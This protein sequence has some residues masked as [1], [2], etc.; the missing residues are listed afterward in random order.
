MSHPDIAG[1]QFEISLTEKSKSI[2]RMHFGLLFF[3]S[4]HI[5]L[6]PVSNHLSGR[7][8]F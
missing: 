1:M 6:A 2:I 8:G 5:V 4:Y 3:Y 7:Q